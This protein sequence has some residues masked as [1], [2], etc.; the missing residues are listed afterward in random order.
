M[1][2]VFFF[3][4][5]NENRIRH[6]VEYIRKKKNKRNSKLVST[7]N[8]HLSVFFLRISYLHMTQKSYWILSP[9]HR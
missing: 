3:D 7:K 5:L 6:K 8:L 9:N 1:Y 4:T 2:K